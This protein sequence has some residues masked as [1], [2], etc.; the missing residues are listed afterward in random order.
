MS[1]PPDIGEHGAAN[2][3]WVTECPSPNSNM[4]TSPFAAVTEDGEY[5]RPDLPTWTVMVAAK[6]ALTRRGATKRDLTIFK[7]LIE[8]MRGRECERRQVVNLGRRLYTIEWATGTLGLSY[9][10][11][12]AQRRFWSCYNQIDH[13]W[14]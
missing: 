5:T 14:V 9:I 3:D 2:V 4:M 12:L 6:A 8:M 10:L 11:L 1:K 13:R 7:I